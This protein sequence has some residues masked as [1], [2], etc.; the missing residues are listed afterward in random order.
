V[1]SERQSA[2]Q[3]DYAPDCAQK[4]KLMNRKLLVVVLTI[5]ASFAGLLLP[6]TRSRAQKSKFYETANEIPGQ[7]IVGLKSDTEL[8]LVG[9][10]SESLAAEHKGELRYV[11]Q[12]ALKGF[13]VNMTESE[14]IALSEDSRVDFVV[15]DGTVSMNTTQ[16]NPTWGLDRIDQT[17]LPLSNSYTYDNNGTGVSAY[18][19]DTG[20]RPTHV[21]FAPLGR[22]VA[23]ADFAP[24]DG[25]PPP[26]PPPPGG[27]SS[28]PPI[29]CPIL[30]GT[31]TP[32]DVTT[33]NT[34]GHG[35]GT[36]VAA[37][38]GGN[39][40][41]VAKNVRL[42]G[43]KVLNSS[44]SGTYES[45]IAGVNWVT[46]HH[47]ANPG[48]AVANMS[49]SGLGHIGLDNAVINS[50]NSGITYAVAASN[51]YRDDASNYSP[52][53]VSQ[54]LT[55]GATD[56]TDTLA[57]FSNVGSVVDLQAPGVDV[58]SAW[59]TSDTAT[60]TI[61]GTSMA[62]PHVCGTAALY[63]QTFP[64]APPVQVHNAIVNGATPNR[65]ND[66]PF[67]T[68]N[69][70]LYSRFF[71]AALAPDTTSTDFDGDEKSDLAVWRPSTGFWHI[72]RS[73]DGGLAGMQWGL[74]S[75]GDK[76]VPGDYDGDG[77]A[78]IAVWRPSDRV[79]YIVNSSNGSQRYEQF[80]LSNDIP[81][82]ADYDADGRTDIAVWRPSDGVWYIRQSTAGDR[83]EAWG[84]GSLGDK[85]V[86]ADYDGDN[87]ADLAIWR[88][89]TGTWWIRNSSDGSSTVRNWGSAAANDVL[90]PADFDGD[91]RSELVVWRPGTGMFYILTITTGVET[92]FGWGLAGDIPVVAD[93]D[94]DGKNDI[95]V[96]RPSDGVWYIVKSSN[97]SHHFEHFGT[98]GDI[99]VPSAYNRY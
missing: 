50:I 42:F 1:S 29:E 56:I 10:T 39:T 17:D 85:P 88:A 52:A 28:V 66:L 35:H 92:Y 58:T 83:F 93:Y 47:L 32:I 59:S 80:G 84:L 60:A 51:N 40:Y 57:D 36:H 73:S 44:G 45:V 34:D 43:V 25:P 9:S 86:A 15:E 67:G 21:E 81:V 7:Y 96:W 95:A 55:V 71:P 70:L 72:K 6:T 8:S 77:K 68:A 97:G 13:S 64:Q 46:S 19:I 27:C 49:L 75:L 62:S 98:N 65:V 99:P 3:L 87:K 16:P 53:R 14:A 82:P 76:I 24:P 54:A 11:F 74:G 94:A 48:P 12:S 33:T 26:P 91:G 78:D 5:A 79:W 69:L 22:A 23:A 61:S 63:L 2:L 38:I 30:N 4:E 90:C 31:Y 18:V 41:G 89:P 37:T 20:I